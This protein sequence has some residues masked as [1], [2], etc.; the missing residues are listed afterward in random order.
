MSKSV[1]KILK[2]DIIHATGSL[3]TCSGVDGGIEASIHA[4]SD[5][6]NDQT[7][8]AI[9]LVDATNAFNSMNRKTALLNVKSICPPFFRFLDNC[10]KTPS[11]LLLE[12][13]MV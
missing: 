9:L 10:Y 6:Y 1:T 12:T 7:S 11:Q 8:E 5:I 2:D 4:M 3:Q 13:F